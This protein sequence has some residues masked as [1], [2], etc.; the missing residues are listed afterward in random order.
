MELGKLVAQLGSA[1][2]GVEDFHALLHEA[3]EEIAVA[4][5]A[6]YVSLQLDQNGSR[7][8]YRFDRLGRVPAT[9]TPHVPLRLAAPAGRRSQLL[10]AE[11]PNA[12][13]FAEAS[14]RFVVIVP[15]QIAKEE[16]LELCIGFGEPGRPVSASDLESFESLATLLAVGASRHGFQQMAIFDPSTKL[17]NRRWLDN[18]LAAEVERARR[19]KQPLALLAIDIDRFKQINDEHGHPA[20]DRV[21]SAVA[22]VLLDSIR[23]CD[24]A[25]RVG[26]DE[27]LVLFPATGAAGAARISGRI[28]ERVRALSFGDALHPL[29]ATI[30]GGVALVDS[31]ST[32][33]SIIRDADAALYEAKR[34]G[35]DAM[36]CPELTPAF[37]EGIPSRERRQSAAF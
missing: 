15:V 19:Y 27:F 1:M 14:L 34:G 3:T 7:W 6:A 23:S 11:G 10:L 4:A 9:F 21:L 26:G 18:H 29:R 32:A 37:E 28:L 22:K 20:G 2:L 16:S 13:P 12:K 25:V 8:E 5:D 33:D 30:S 17:Y 31:H 36:H 24:F 35:R